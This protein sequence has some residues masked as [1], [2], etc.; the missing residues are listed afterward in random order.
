[1]SGP[2]VGS[3]HIIRHD[4]TGD[5]FQIWSDSG[6][7][8]KL[9]RRASINIGIALSFSLSIEAHRGVYSTLCKIKKCSH[10]SGTNIIN[11]SISSS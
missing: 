1:M 9:W 11:Q 8:G 6:D 7:Q 3:L 5:D 4:E 2:A 10:S